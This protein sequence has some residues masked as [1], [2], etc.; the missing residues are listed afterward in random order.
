M[1]G[2]PL[3]PPPGARGLPIIVDWSRIG[4]ARARQEGRFPTV[5]KLPLV[6]D[7][8]RRVLELCP[9]GARV[10]DVGA[11][12]RSLGERLRAKDPSIAYKSMDVDDTHPHDYRTL[13]EI[14][15]TFDSIYCLSVIEHLSP[16]E[17]FELLERLFCLTA[18]GGRL[19]VLTPNVF[20]PNY[21]WRDVTHTTPWPYNDLAGAR[22]EAGYGEVALY[23]VADNPRLKDRLRRW[24]WHG[25]LKMLK[26][27]FAIHILA[28]A[29][30][31]ER[32]GWPL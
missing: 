15:E 14:D 32:E 25:M 24:R 2:R 23:R 22:L 20:H 3:R 28:V 5:L 27:D 4:R 16:A 31:R 26:I 29:H 12:D 9:P 7:L 30:R 8:H 17:G 13:E 18:P 11:H 1:R 10:L 6:H 19:V 21:F